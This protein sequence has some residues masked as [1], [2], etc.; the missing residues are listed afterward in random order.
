MGN[1]IGD[2][3]CGVRGLF[4]RSAISDQRSGIAPR[5]PPRSSLEW[6][7]RA[8][9]GHKS[10]TLATRRTAVLEERDVFCVSRCLAPGCRD[11]LELEEIAFAGHLQAVPADAHARRSCRQ[12]RGRYW[13]VEQGDQPEALSS[14][15]QSDAVGGASILSLEAAT[16]RLA[17]VAA[18]FPSCARR[19]T[20]SRPRS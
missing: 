13:D 18:T 16:R 12:S 11:L 3:G 5:N 14:G 20:S 6:D 15:Y 1:E 8:A 9:A 10:A 17:M 19:A 7:D 4:L 2:A